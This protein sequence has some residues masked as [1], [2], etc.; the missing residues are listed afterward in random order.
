MMKTLMLS[1]AFVLLFAFTTIA[2]ETA[3]VDEQITSEP[4]VIA[5]TMHGDWCGKCKIMD[6]KLN[7]I[8]A[9]FKDTGILF[10]ILDMTNDFTKSQA[11]LQARVMGIYDLFEQ[12]EGRTGYTVIIDAET[13][14]E[15]DRI[16]HDLSEDEMRSKLRAVI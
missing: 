13:G 10:T 2:S 9:E 12:H 3:S 4:K 11:G 15:I 14:K 7:S 6:P 5:V 1:T 16:T 8:K